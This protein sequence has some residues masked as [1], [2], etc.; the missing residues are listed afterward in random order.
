MKQTQNI[1]YL[2]CGIGFFLIL[3]CSMAS[4]HVGKKYQNTQIS[5]NSGRNQSININNGTEAERDAQMNPN[6]A[7]SRGGGQDYAEIDEL[8]MPDLSS[9]SIHIFDNDNSNVSSDRIR[10]PTDVSLKQYQSLMPHLQQPLQVNKDADEY[11]NNPEE[12]N[13]AYTNLYQPLRQNQQSE[14]D[15]QTVPVYSILKL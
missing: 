7:T 9:S 11:C 4:F 6:I 10:L 15:L 2:S 12:E 1:V 3:S 5:Q 13:K 8:E 14:N